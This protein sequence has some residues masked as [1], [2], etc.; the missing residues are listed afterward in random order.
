M[1]TM[2]R[3]VRLTLIAS[4]CIPAALAGPTASGQTTATLEPAAMAQAWREKAERTL[5]VGNLWINGNPHAPRQI[6]LVFDLNQLEADLDRIEIV[7]ATLT[8]KK[9]ASSGYIG[10]TY[11][12]H[13]FGITDNDDWDGRDPVP[14]GSEHGNDKPGINWQNAPKNDPEANGVIDEGTRRFARLKMTRDVQTA[15]ATDYLRWATGQQKDWGKADRDE[16]NRI[17]VWAVASHGSVYRYHGKG[18]NAPTLKVTYRAGSEQAAPNA[19]ATEPTAAP[20]RGA[21]AAPDAPE[22]SSAASAGVRTAADVGPTNRPNAAALY[23]LVGDG[24]ADDTAGIQKTFKHRGPIYLPP[25]EYRI[26][27]PIQVAAKTRVYGGGGAWNAKGQ[28]VIRYDGPEGGHVLNVENAHFFQMRQVVVNGGGKAAIGVYWNYS[29]NETLL[30]DVA[31]TGTLEHGLYVTKTWYA[32]FTRLVVRNNQGN[33]I[34]LDRNHDPEL[35]KGAINDVTFFRCRASHNGENGE[36]DGRANIATGY[37]FGSF[38]Y[39]NMVNVIGCS[40]EMNG[41]PGVYLAGAAGMIRFAGCYIEQNSRALNKHEPD[42]FLARPDRP[43]VGY[44]ADIIDDTT[45]TSGV[46]FDTCYMHGNGGIWLRGAAGGRQ[47]TVFRHV[48][49]PTVIWA[50]HDGWQWDNDWKPP[51]ADQPGVIYREDGGTGQWRWGPGGGE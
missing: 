22:T 37:G 3:S 28:T 47:K 10:G 27:Q 1:R 46:V 5:N 29:V 19:E 24:E 25:G 42:N 44:R 43:S 21:N 4:L 39:N 13:V 45:E 31:I 12:T 41:G 38:H 34:T 50:E 9:A 23:N 8:L 40:F 18:P 35:A 17:S 32:N 11:Q 33:G 20:A 36:Y 14:H 7:E 2:P 48:M 30:E 16:D 51:V 15:D 26:T 49:H 6:L